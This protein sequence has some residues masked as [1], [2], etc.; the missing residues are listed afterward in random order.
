VVSDPAWQPACPAA[1]EEDLA[2][3]LVQLLCDL[4]ARLAAP[5]DEHMTRRQLPRAPVVLD[6]DLE[7][8]GRQRRRPRRTVRALVGAGAEHDRPRGDRAARGVQVEAAAGAWPD[9]S[10]LDPFPHRGVDGRG[11]ALQVAHDLV[12]WHEAVGIVL[13]VGVAGK[14]DAPVRGDEAEAVPAPAPGLPDA[15]SLEH[16][17]RHA[18]GRELP[19]DR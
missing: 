15:A 11:I 18:G 6:V 13:V 19:A 4:A 8:A 9:P 10:D 16:D 1:R 5:D 3:G 7:Q 12:A 17:M 2:S 14:L